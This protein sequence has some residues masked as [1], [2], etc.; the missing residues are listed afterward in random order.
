MQISEVSFQFIIAIT[1]FISSPGSELPSVS[2]YFFKFDR[3]F[4]VASLKLTHNVGQNWHS[5]LHL[6][7]PRFLVL[8]RFRHVGS[9]TRFFFMFFLSPFFFFFFFFLSRLLRLL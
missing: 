6:S 7:K 2:F 3:A 5:F 9:F 1:A 8:S 4:V